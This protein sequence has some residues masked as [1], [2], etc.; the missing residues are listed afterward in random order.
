[1]VP[2]W[3]RKNKYYESVIGEPHKKFVLAVLEGLKEAADLE[4]QEEN[5][6]IVDVFYKDLEKDEAMAIIGAI[7]EGIESTD[8]ALRLMR[9]FL[10]NR[11]TVDRVSRLLEMDFEKKNNSACSRAE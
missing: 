11:I 10:T 4:E 5:N 7:S 3:S 8:F 9:M 1:M 6:V 2:W